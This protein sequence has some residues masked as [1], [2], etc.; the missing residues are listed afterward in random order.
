MLF[1]N[2]DSSSVVFTNEM[3]IIL[4]LVVLTVILAIVQ[5]LFIIFQKQITELV[6]KI[7]K[8]IN[9]DAATVYK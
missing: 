5:I 1:S 7:W 6:N 8:S 9:R 2:R 3:I 4:A